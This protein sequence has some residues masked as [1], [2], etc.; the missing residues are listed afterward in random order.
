MMQSD[1]ICRD[2]EK[3]TSRE[4]RGVCIGRGAYVFGVRYFETI[5]DEVSQESKARH[6]H[7]GMA[8]WVRRLHP[9]HP[10]CDAEAQRLGVIAL[11]SESH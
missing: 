11:Y 3:A 7:R 9:T 5:V 6:G 1:A 4:T 2:T 8:R 10:E